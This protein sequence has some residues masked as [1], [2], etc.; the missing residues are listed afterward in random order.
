[1]SYL[2]FSFLAISFNTH[3]EPNSKTFATITTSMGSIK[4]EL[5]KDKA[6]ATVDNFIQ[7]AE[8]GYYGGT[9]F[10]RVIPSFMVQGGGFDM[11]FIKKST[12]DPVINEA[13]PFVPNRRGTIAMARTSAPDSATSQFFINVIDNNSLN[14][15]RTKPGYTVFGKVV[16]GMIVADQISNVKTGVQ[17]RMRDVPMTPIMI[18]SVTINYAPEKLTMKPVIQKPEPQAK[19]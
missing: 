9:I 6:P 7:Y 17:N 1:V 5:F 13:N 12:K 11:N 16:E 2:T 4:L 18:Q 15:T 14:K 19:K 3:A 8:S 10:H